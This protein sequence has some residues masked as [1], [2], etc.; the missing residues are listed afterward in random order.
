MKLEDKILLQF[1]L[2]Q[3]Q[4]RWLNKFVH[5]SW[6]YENGVVNVRGS[7]GL[8]VQ[9]LTTIPVQFGEITGNFDCSNNRL[10]SLESLPKIVRTIYCHNNP[11]ELNDKLFEDL[12]RIGGKNKVQNS[13]MLL[14]ELYNQISIQFSITDKIVINE[15]WSSYMNILDNN[16]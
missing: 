13:N 3:Q 14:S 15:I 5:G 4:I 10:T 9:N 7:V 6:K 8:Q 1:G 11:F 16:Y 2:T 12:A